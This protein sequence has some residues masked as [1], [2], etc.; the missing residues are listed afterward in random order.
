MQPDPVMEM[1]DHISEQQGSMM[2]DLHGFRV[3]QRAL[4]NHLGFEAATTR[5]SKAHALKTT[6]LGVVA[7][8]RKPSSST[9]IETAGANEE[10]EGG[11]SERSAAGAD[12]ARDA[13]GDGAD[14]AVSCGVEGSSRGQESV[15][16]EPAPGPAKESG[17]AD[18][19]ETGQVRIKVSVSKDTA[20]AVSALASDE[21]SASPAMLEVQAHDVTPPALPAAGEPMVKPEGTTSSPSAAPAAPNA[22]GVA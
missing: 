11:D 22:T 16:V 18:G 12:A 20:V 6:G 5:L 14:C 9:E 21:L 2:R 13:A 19:V 3:R 1:L 17:V 7:T 15:T 4:E 8:R 10:C